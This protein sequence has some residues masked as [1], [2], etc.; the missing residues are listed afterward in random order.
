V[1]WY[2]DP[3]P[4]AAGHLRREIRRYLERHATEDADVAGAEVVAGELITNGVRHAGGPLWVSLRWPDAHPVLTVADLGPGFQLDTSLPEDPAAVGGRGL[5]I[6]SRL[7][8]SLEREARRSGG[9]IVSATLPVTKPFVASHDPPRR[10]QGVLPTL[11]EA[12]PGVGFGQDAFL[13]ALVVQLA[14][15]VEERTGPDQAEAAVAQV[16]TDVGGQMEAEFRR[17]RQV[18]DRLTPEQIGEC[19]VRL[20]HAIDGDFVVEEATD[21]RI[22]LVNSRCPF[23][24]VVRRAPALCRMTSSVFGGIAAR[25]SGQGATV[26]LEERIAV[27]DP[28]CRVVVWLDADHPGARQWGHRYETPVDADPTG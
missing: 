17:A 6:V 26:V 9:S 25:N 5:H 21:E 1:D 20:K 10:R 2:L 4:A 23:G 19:Y 24:D 14:Q 22:V 8:K 3:D 18:V 12:E 11:D 27:G 28:E 7:A 13:R 15:A 16:G